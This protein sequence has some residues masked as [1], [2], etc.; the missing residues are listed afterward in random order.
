[1]HASGIA[2]NR[3]EHGEDTEF[4]AA[5]FGAGR[6]LLTDEKASCPFPNS[7]PRFAPLWPGRFVKISSEVVRRMCTSSRVKIGS[8]G[9]SHLLLAPSGL[10]PQRLSPGSFLARP[11][12]A[13]IKEPTPFQVALLVV[14]IF[15]QG[16]RRELFSSSFPP[17][18]CL[19]G[20]EDVSPVCSCS[21]HC[22]YTG[23]PSSLVE[24]SCLISGSI[25]KEGGALPRFPVGPFNPVLRICCAR[26]L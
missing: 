15:E 23:H 26:A 17:P 25:A 10:P 24:F 22:P 12:F 3:S 20:F 13:S 21:W 14:A 8:A 9:Q 18:A 5:R 2:A 1:V 6:E 7:S 16:P 11:E 19:R 4:G